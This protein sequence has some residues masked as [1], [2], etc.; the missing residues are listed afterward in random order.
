MAP[1]AAWAVGLATGSPAGV[2]SRSNWDNGNGG[3][4]GQILSGDGGYA[5]AGTWGS[6]NGDDGFVT[7]TST[8]SADA[9]LDTTAF[10]PSIVMG[11]NVLGNTVDM[12]VRSAAIS[13]LDRDR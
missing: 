8:A 1:P 7:G 5:H 9:V 2:S 11:A 4:G 10:N 13:R 6:N 3:D 12:T